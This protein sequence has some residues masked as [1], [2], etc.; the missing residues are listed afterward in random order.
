MNNDKKPEIRE[1]NVLSP[2][3]WR[4]YPGKVIIYS[5]DEQ[6]VIGVGDTE[7]VAFAQA[8][9]SGVRGLWHFHYAAHPDIGII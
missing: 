9:A 2:E 5:E 8:E 7:D 6:R 3:I 1:I 4:K